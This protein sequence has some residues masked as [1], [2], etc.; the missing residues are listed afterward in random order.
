MRTE[1]QRANRSAAQHRIYASS[2]RELLSRCTRARGTRR[3]TRLCCALHVLKR[4]VARPP[5]SPIGSILTARDPSRARHHARGVARRG[6]RG[7]V[8]R[9]VRA[10]AA[11]SRRRSGSA[12]PA[13]LPCLRAAA[14]QAASRPPRRALRR[15][16]RRRRSRRAGRHSRQRSGCVS[17]AASPCAPLPAARRALTPPRACRVRGVR[18]SVR[19]CD[20]GASVQADLQRSPH[21]R[22]RLPLP[23]QAGRPR[24][25]QLPAGVGGQRQPERACPVSS[26]SRAPGC[27][28]R[29][30]LR[31]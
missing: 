6:R 30:R 5:A 26:S 17:A 15:V 16:T 31:W 11:Q 25:A 19:Q 23:G 4:A 8:C 14:E 21:A 12:G 29:L 27:A 20:A 7:G 10:V 3:D 13:G 28:L 24:G 2:R 9:R 22:A 1:L 18:R